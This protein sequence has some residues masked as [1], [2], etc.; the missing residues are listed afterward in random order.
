[1]DVQEKNMQTVEEQEM[2]EAEMLR[3]EENLEDEMQEE[4]GQQ[5]S[6]DDD[7]EEDCKT[8][9]DKGKVAVLNC[10]DDQTSLPNN[11][12]DKKKQGNVL[13]LNNEVVKMRKEVKRVRVLI[14][15]KLI[16]HIVALKKR[17]G[18]EAEVEKNQRRAARLLE[19]V[20]S[21]K[22]LSP[23]LV[24]KTALQ[25]QLNFE[26]VCR[27]QKSTISDR[28]I[29]RIATH[30]Q[31][32]KKIE[33]IK[34]AV[35]AFKEDRMKSLELEG[36]A[37][38]R[39]QAGKAAQPSQEQKGKPKKERKEEDKALGS[40]E[41]ADTVVK[42]EV[43]KGSE[44]AP[45]AKAE[46][47]KEIDAHSAGTSN[48]TR[49]EKSNLVSVKPASVKKHTKDGVKSEAQTKAAEEN[50]KPPPAPQTPEKRKEED[51]SGVESSDDEEKMYF[52]DSTEERFYK[53]S[54]QSEESE[55]DDFFLGKMSKFK[56]KK[57]KQPGRDGEKKD[58]VE[59]LKEDS[60]GNATSSDKLQR[61]LDE[62][63]SRLKSRANPCQS[64][65]CSSL[66][67]KKAKGGPGRGRGGGKFTG[68][69][70]PKGLSKD[71]SK[72]STK[73]Q[74]QERAVSH[75][76]KRPGFEEKAWGGRGRGRGR[77]DVRR[78]KDPGGR[79]AFSHS[80]PQP[81]LHPSWEA[82]KKRKEQQGHILAFQGK[83]IKFDDDD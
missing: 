63:E 46:K 55:D 20:H 3:E 82:S 4:G 11:D 38:P 9:E 70:K 76:D 16:R 27:D 8:D 74:S 13:N 83:K 51:E 67:G 34:A 47:K 32:D 30:P 6:G 14:I 79:G 29:A 25:K 61:E 49:E 21:M 62:L 54:S 72:Q 50:S 48:I 24:T 2:E 57:K 43:L 37:P 1:M 40:S 68:Q 5:S 7:D 66:T 64:V 19:E 69:I 33:S 26:Q 42:A 31:F 45:D 65:F 58:K 44:D 73:F 60:A 41:V 12:T 80:A 36:E 15:R 81:A 52:D 18:N 53:Q 28:A 75:S 71:F 35:K 17:K 22:T 78:Q 59:E 23:D 56:M 77:G 39:K 10:T